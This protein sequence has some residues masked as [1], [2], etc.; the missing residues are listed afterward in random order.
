MDTIEEN[1][2]SI[3]A[4]PS[5]L[6]MARFLAKETESQEEMFMNTHL[7]DC[8]ECGRLFAEAQQQTATFMAA[9]PDLQ[10]LIRTRKV[11]VNPAAAL[12][13]R[14][15]AFGRWLRLAVPFALAS[16]A[17]T[18]GALYWKPFG[19]AQDLTA[20]GE[21]R[22][23]LFV[24]GAQAAK[25][26]VVCRSSDTLQLGL[27]SPQPMHFAVLYQDDQK[28][29]RAYMGG[30]SMPKVGKPKGENLPHSL[31]LTGDWRNETLYC[32]WSPRPFS[33][34]EA[35]AMAGK[36]AAMLAG[37]LHLQTFQLVNGRP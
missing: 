35:K 3:P 27:T 14:R 13:P 1:M 8:G 17:F 5:R 12:Q 18:V 10:G 29:I 34:G 22:F 6:L 2:G 20:K 7:R 9:H 16:L 11:R 15:W 37:S 33:M 24:N 28:G 19:G 25:D 31:I 21:S 32:I 23:Y 30:G 36:S 26:T 4:H